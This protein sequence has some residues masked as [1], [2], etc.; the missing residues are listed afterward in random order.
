MYN[1]S[2]GK[3]KDFFMT[4]KSNVSLCAISRVLAV[5]GALSLAACA[6][7]NV[8]TEYNGGYMATPTVDYVEGLDVYSAPHK[9]SFLNQ[10]AMNYRSY[11]IYNART[12]GYPDMGELFAQKAVTAFSGE[13]P[14][15]GSM[16]ERDGY[17][18]LPLAECQLLPYQ[19]L[20]LRGGNVP[21]VRPGR[22]CHRR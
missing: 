15:P 3:R 12:S 5:V 16:P 19:P 21:A 4:S 10:L 11:A 18:P 6:R 8:G 20:S 1:V 9:D 13:T 14:F 17:Q 2:Q 22:H 7:S